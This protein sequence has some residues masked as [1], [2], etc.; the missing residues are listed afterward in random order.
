MLIFSS[1]KLGIIAD[2]AQIGKQWSFFVL[3]ESISRNM[4]GNMISLCIEEPR[5]AIY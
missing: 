4:L 3:N 5:G 1:K 2:K